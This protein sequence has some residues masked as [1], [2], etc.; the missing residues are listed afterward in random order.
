MLDDCENFLHFSSLSAAF[1]AVASRRADATLL[2]YEGGQWS[3]GEID[4][5]SDTIAR[6]ILLKFGRRKQVIGVVSNELPMVLASYLGIMKS[7]SAYAGLDP[8]LP[9]ERLAA[10]REVAAIS[11]CIADEACLPKAT[12][13]MG[14]SDRVLIPTPGEVAADRGDLGVAIAKSDVCH[15]LFTSGSTG[16]PK[17]VPRTHEDQLHNVERHRP[18]GLNT[19][20]TA[21]LISR[22]GFFDSVSNPFA[23]ILYGAKVC[24]IRLLTGAE[25]LGRWIEQE[26]AT[27]YY[28]FPTVF[29]QLLATS[30]HPDAL[31]SLRLVYL[32]GESVHP[33]DLSHACRLLR[34][35]AQI[36]VGLGSTET[37]VTALKLHTVGGGA[38]DVVTVG[39]PLGGI[40][41]E[42]WGDDRLP[43]PPMEIG[44]IV[45]RSPFIF[46]GYLGADRRAERSI[47]PDPDQSGS[48]IFES[49][50]LGYF[51]ADGE[52]VVTGRRDD[53]VKLRGF[54]IELGDV[55]TTLRGRPGVREA[56]AFLSSSNE[57]AQDDEL[58]AFISAST[59]VAGEEELRQWLRTK[60][61]DHM[62]PARVLVVEDF[63]RA[64]NGK[65]DRR[66]LATL[67]KSIRR[68]ELAAR[69]QE[70]PQAGLETRV[71]AIWSSLLNIPSISRTDRFFEVGGNSLKALIFMSLLN[72]QLSAEMPLSFLF[73]EDQLSAF[74]E[75]C[76][77][78]LAA[79]KDL[80]DGAR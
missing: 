31:G 65:V 10:L 73:E 79:T 80:Q 12:A 17:A 67:Y 24:A 69:P 44:T 61:P 57:A 25:E 36:A 19:T 43:A 42:I 14:S 48:Y 39:R 56:A 37:G 58:V 13:L 34:P 5:W 51:D 76:S 40:R 50:D 21:T 35:D 46:H 1:T 49:P 77:T 18:L 62:V 8:A 53:L 75:R 26:R 20:D 11:G 70:A 23:A 71:A 45:F 52:L 72:Q 15:I 7:G 59:K 30:P 6:Q 74:C 4:A 64:L 55:E 22:R 28:S 78:H 9:D 41:I 27:V 68:A 2:S 38:P 33:D 60:L 63:P 47:Y 16:Q 29:R 66:G 32:G 3:Y 54:R